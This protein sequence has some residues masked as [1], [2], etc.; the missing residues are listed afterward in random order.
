MV[1]GQHADFSLRQRHRDSFGGIEVLL[2]ETPTLDDSDIRM[3]L[4][5]RRG[6]WQLSV[7]VANGTRMI[8]HGI[9]PGVELNYIVIDGRGVLYMQLTL[10][11]SCRR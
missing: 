8:I 3:V 5:K 4:K 7:G 6:R 2:A 1:L 10:A 11:I 9:T